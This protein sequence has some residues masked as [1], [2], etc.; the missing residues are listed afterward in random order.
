MR[1]R[2][3]FA[4]SCLILA[5]CASDARTEVLT[6]SLVADDADPMRPGDPEL[7]RSLLLNN[8]TEDAPYLSCGVPRSVVQTFSLLGLDIL[9]EPLKLPERERGNEELGYYLSYAKAPSGV[10]VVTTNCLLCHASK[11]GDSVVIGLGNPNLDFAGQGGIFGASDIALDLVK[12]TLPD[13]EFDELGRFQRVQ[14][15]ASGWAKPDTVGMNPADM[16]FGVLASHRDA[17]TLVWSDEPDPNARFD[18]GIV[19]T[20]VPAWWNTHRRDRMFYT[21]FGRGDHARIMMSAALMCLEDTT[22]A[23]AIDEYFPHI[24]AFIQSLRP[25]KYEAVAKRSIDPE[26]AGRG[27][28]VFVSTCTRCHGDAENDIAPRPLVSIAEV[29]TDPVYAMRA[30]N[31]GDGI[32]YYF[33]FFNRSWYGTHGSAGRLEP[34]TEAGYSAPPLDGVWATAPYFHNGSVPTLEAVLDPSLRPAIFRRS[35]KP[36]EYDFERL[37]WPFEVVEEKGTDRS[38]YDA[39]RE[40]YGNGGHTFAAALSADERRALLEYL[41]TL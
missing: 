6:A 32:G 14:E 10:E 2:I 5:A 33:D 1:K 17:E 20:D 34:P 28:E 25:P 29:G 23:E 22:E 35:V 40:A 15:A 16:M 37:G 24:Q 9:K 38:V 18:V 39:T 36:E 11:L 27:R 21:G 30:A 41:K 3:V 31:G 7:G 12:L 19:F 4:S 13:R 26:R 8:G